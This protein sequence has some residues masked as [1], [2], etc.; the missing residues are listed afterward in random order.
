MAMK[1]LKLPVKNKNSNFEELSLQKDWQKMN[2][3]NQMAITKC[4]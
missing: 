1:N 4:N 3:I 2:Q